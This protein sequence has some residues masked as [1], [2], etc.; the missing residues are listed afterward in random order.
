MKK[1]VK[2]NL[3]YALSIMIPIFVVIILFIG[4][5]NA[6]II[7]FEAPKIEVEGEVTATITINFGNEKIY[8]EDLTMINA[9]VFDFLQK[10][11]VIGDIVLETTYW[12]Q[13]DSYFVDS[14]SYNGEKYEADSSH[15]WAYYI[16]G[17]AGMV[18]AD[19]QLV[20]QGDLIEWKF[21]SF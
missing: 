18:G 17:E 16:N 3:R 6:G 1:E 2:K 21:E 7:T 15:Y 14:I 13:Y 4:G 9:T 11:E 19:K 12:E 5:I 20:K 8:S 10:I